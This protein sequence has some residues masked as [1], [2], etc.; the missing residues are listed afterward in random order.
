[1]PKNIFSFQKADF[2]MHSVFSDGT[3]SPE[4]LLDKIKIAGIDVFSLTD[5]DT[6]A[7]CE[8]MS[9]LIK[10]DRAPY[11]IPGIEFSTED[12]HGKYHIL[13]YGFRMEDSEVTRVAAYCHESRLIKAQK[14][15]DFL[16]DAFGF[17]FSDD[18]IRLVLQQNNP[19]KPHIARLCVSHG[20]AKSI[21]DAIDNYLSK[22][23]GKDEKLTP[24]QAIQTILLSD[25]VPVL[26]HGFFGSGAQRLSENEMILRIDRLQSYG[27][28]GLE[29][30]YSGF[31]EKQAAF[32]CA[33]AEK[34]KLFITAGSDYHG[35][36]KAVRLGTLCADV[37]PSPLPYLK[38]FIRY[39]FC[40]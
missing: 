39:I 17:A 37:C 6:C 38:V 11:F 4:E 25:G 29:A 28:L 13:G 20:Y 36:N 5:H 32:L 26:A 23:P 35:E 34:N 7:G 9:A 8:Q 22:Y 40:R 2:H 16:K 15:M 24:Q 10:K 18:E 31:S 14:R 3:D 33:L 21:T 30:F 1:M 19:G 12:K 27:L